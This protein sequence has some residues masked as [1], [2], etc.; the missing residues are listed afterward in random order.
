MKWAIVVAVI[1]AAAISAA[2]QDKSTIT[3][4]DVSVSG[5]VVIVTAQVDG[6]TRELQ[7]NRSVLYCKVPQPGKYTMV[8]LPNNRGIYECSNVDLF[9]P[10]VDSQSEEKFGEYCLLER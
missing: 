7:C 8:R 10:S 9:N 4:K 5:D 6:N 1:L 3:V 2:A